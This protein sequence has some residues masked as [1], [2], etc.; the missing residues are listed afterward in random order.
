MK[1]MQYMQISA[2][3]NQVSVSSVYMVHKVSFETG[4]QKGGGRK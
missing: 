4:G 1:K 2:P 3:G